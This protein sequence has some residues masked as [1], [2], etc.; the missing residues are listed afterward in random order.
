MPVFN[1][2]GL[3]ISAGDGRDSDHN[4]FDHRIRRLYAEGDDHMV[5]VCNVCLKVRY[6]ADGVRPMAWYFASPNNPT[7]TLCRYVWPDPVVDDDTEVWK[8]PDLGLYGLPIEHI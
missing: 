5:E 6:E 8:H 7:G 1:G 4:C 3:V 2:T